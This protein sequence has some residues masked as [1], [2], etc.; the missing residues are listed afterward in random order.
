LWDIL[1]GESLL[2][3]ATALLALEFGLALLVGGERPTFTFGLPVS[4]I[5]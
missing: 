1:E 3:D 4:E 2:N 5:W